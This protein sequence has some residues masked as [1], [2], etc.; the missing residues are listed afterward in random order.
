MLSQNIGTSGTCTGIEILVQVLKERRT[1]VLRS[2]MP[3]KPDYRADRLTQ[4]RRILFNAIFFLEFIYLAAGLN[5]KA[6]AAGVEGMAFGANFHLDLAGSRAGHKFV[7]AGASYLDL[8][9]LR[10]DTFLHSFHLFL[11]KPYPE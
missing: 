7:A 11:L 4:Y 2:Q 6:F 1:V 9:V 5:H 10:M 8:V 3:P